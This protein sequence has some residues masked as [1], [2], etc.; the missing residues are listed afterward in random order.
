MLKKR[1]EIRISSRYLI[2]AIFIYINISKR[3]ESDYILQGVD[4]DGNYD[5][6]TY[7]V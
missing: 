5:K 6:V 4:I 7:D 3:Y 1:K 2:Y